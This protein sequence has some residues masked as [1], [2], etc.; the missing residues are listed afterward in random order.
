MFR[1]TGVILL[2]TSRMQAINIDH[3][4]NLHAT[5]KR[6]RLGHFRVHKVKEGGVRMFES[7]I[8]PGQ[9]I[10]LKD[11]K[12]DCNVSSDKFGRIFINQNLDV[13]RYL[14]FHQSA[15]DIYLFHQFHYQSKLYNLK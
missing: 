4:N 1:D 10:R 9:F 3:E 2:G 8:Q 5:G 13:D 12:I 11:G 14:D 7:I 15:G 6:T